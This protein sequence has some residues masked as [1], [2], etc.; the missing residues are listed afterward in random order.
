MEKE[1]YFVKQCSICKCDF[2]TKFKKD[3]FC[4]YSC[5]E[6]FKI[7]KINEKWLKRDSKKLEEEQRER[8]R[9]NE[10][11]MRMSATRSDPSWMKK[12]KSVQG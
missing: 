1:K 3:K 2:E 9:K 10:P 5:Q 6:K 12:F 4:G 11:K 8:N 7:T